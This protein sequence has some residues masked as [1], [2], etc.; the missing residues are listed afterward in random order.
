M[1][2]MCYSSQQKQFL[3]AACGRELTRG[4]KQNTIGLQIKLCVYT[5]L[6]Y[7]FHE[8]CAGTLLVYQFHDSRMWYFKK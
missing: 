5:E 8:T 1:V 3:E 6:V 7:Y 4:N 2:K